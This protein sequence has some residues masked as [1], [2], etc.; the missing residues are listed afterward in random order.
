[1]KVIDVNQIN[2]NRIVYFISNNNIPVNIEA[3][4]TH[5]YIGIN[6]NLLLAE[7]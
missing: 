3:S 5:D 7:K 1:M 2:V 4:Y 6:D